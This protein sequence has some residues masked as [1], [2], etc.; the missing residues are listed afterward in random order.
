M[1]AGSAAPTQ[2]SLQPDVVRGFLDVVTR[3]LRSTVGVDA[4]VAAVAELDRTQPTIAVTVDL[5]G[6]IR[7]PVTWV[8]PPTIA[9]ELVRRLMDDP[10]PSPDSAADGA[11]ELANILTG[12]AS[13]ALEAHG[14]V[15]EMGPPRVHVGALP[16]GF[17]VRMTTSDG[18]IDVIL[19]LV[20]G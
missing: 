7:G 1:S 14:F 17:N 19:S 3:C 6:D 11:T 20:H 9:L 2:A 10:D 4:V 16:A 13:E 18:P 8:F 12:R 15:C 5:A